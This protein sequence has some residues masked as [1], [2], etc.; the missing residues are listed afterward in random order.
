MTQ[1][2]F[3]RQRFAVGTLT[4]PKEKKSVPQAMIELY[5]DRSSWFLELFLAHIKL[6]GTAIVIAGVI[7]LILGI[8]IAEHRRFAP[9]VIAYAM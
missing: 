1:S 8:L 7:G 3:P 6:C 4:A 5:R 2:G 9:A